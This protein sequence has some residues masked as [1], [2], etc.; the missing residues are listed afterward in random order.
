MRNFIHTSKLYRAVADSDKVKHSDIIEDNVF[1]PT[2]DQAK[3]LLSILKE[4]ENGL[5]GTLAATAKKITLV[6]PKSIEEVEQLNDLLKKTDETIDGLTQAQKQRLKIE[7][8][9][10]A[11]QSKQAVETQKLKEALSQQNKANK[12]LAREQLGLV[13]AYQKAS[14]EL[15]ELRTAYKNLALAGREQGVVGRGLLQVVQEQDAKLKA[16]DATVG[17]HQR[18]VGNYTG[19]MKGLGGILVGTA[20][21][22]GINEDAIHSL[23]MGYRNIVK[24]LTG[25]KQAK[26]GLAN[27][28]NTEVGANLKNTAATNAGTESV[29]KMTIAQRILNAVRSAGTAGIFAAI[30]VAALLAAAIIA[31]VE[32]VSS[33]TKAE[34]E[35]SK[36]VD[37]AIIK[38]EELRKEHNKSVFELRRLDVEYQKVTGAITEFQAIIKT[39]GIDYAETIRGIKDETETKLT[40]VTGFWNS[41][42]L[43]ILS[44]GDVMKENAMKFEESF[45]ASAEGFLKES[46]QLKLHN[47]L[48]KIEEEKQASRLADIERDKQREL[49]LLQVD[50]IKDDTERKRQ[51]LKINAQFAT[52]DVLIS[53]LSG[54]TKFNLIVAINNKLAMEL[55]KINEELAEKK[56]ALDQEEFDRLRKLDEMERKALDDMSKARLKALEK[57][58]AEEEKLRAEQAGKEMAE[59]EKLLTNISDIETRNAEIG[60]KEDE[61]RLEE[62]NEQHNRELSL[63]LEARKK[64]LLTEQQYQDARLKLEQNYDDELKSISRGRFERE[65][66]LLDKYTDAVFDGLEERRQKQQDAISRELSDIDKSIQLQ[67][68]LAVQGLDNTLE[69]QEKR[70]AEALAKKAELDKRASRQKE[71]QDLAEIFLEFVKGFAKTGDINA[72]AK[73]LAETL[74]AKGI[75][76]AIAGNF[77][78][79]VE[80]FKG[81][82]GPTEDANLIGFSSGESVLTAEA[83][84]KNAGLA[85]AIN[86]DPD[87]GAVRWAVEHMILPRVRLPDSPLLRE[88]AGVE[89]LRDD[90]KRIEK[91]VRESGDKVE[92]NT[93]NEMIRTRIREGIKKQIIY[94]ENRF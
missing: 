53:E 48:I 17:Q 33:S 25:Y 80:N 76:K 2:I 22:F 5:K 8:Q 35:R 83:T 60:K 54:T 16:L 46:D 49:K 40:K 90:L 38:N 82:G 74:L 52:E 92:W 12:E 86:E 37:G 66:K 87:K 71:A 32:A 26:S 14:R 24:I 4:L 23:E 1:Q 30:A 45:T 51:Q 67:Q 68:Q 6:N 81:K 59:Q 13:N 21:L 79:G 34:H 75:S 65:L 20:K 70:R 31:V 85:T 42:W 84:S 3:E 72:P 15:N 91:A 39:L 62:I 93:L 50:T 61:L 58:Y 7:Q 28:A 27:I 64:G 29:K 18:N 69:F 57:R 19:A 10:V 89:V 77:A 73:A 47:K 63:L 78:E 94:K 41:L 56:R 55:N 44:G 43:K 88:I 11:A 36:A 9:L